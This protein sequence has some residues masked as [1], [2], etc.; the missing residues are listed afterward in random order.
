MSPTSTG[1]TTWLTP[2]TGVRDALYRSQILVI[3]AG[4]GGLT[5]AL[6]LQRQGFRVSV[7]ERAAEL[8]ELG[9]GVIITPNAMHALNFLGIG[10]SIV[11]SANLA[12]DLEFRHFKTAKLLQRRVVADISNRYGAAVYQ[13]HRADL[14]GTLSS[15]VLANDPD[16]IHLDHAF[17]DLS[18]DENAVVARFA[19]G[20]V[21]EG[22]ALIGCDGGRSIV[23]ERLYGR[24][25]VAYAGQVAFRAIV[26]A[27]QLPKG[28]RLH[29]RCVYCGPDRMLMHYALRK[30]SLMNIIAIA[31]QHEWQEEQWA[32]HGEIRELSRLYID[33]HPNALEM[34][35]AVKPDVL[36]KWGLHDREPLPQW[37]VGRVS[38]LGDAAHPFTPFLGQGACMA[39]E[40]GTILSRCFAGTRNPSEALRLYETA[41]RKRANTAQLRSRERAKALQGIFVDNFD[42][43]TNTQDVELFDGLFAYNPVTAPIEPGPE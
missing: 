23:R 24:E 36:F 25:P 40:D 11:K 1:P 7:Y 13:V 41:R 37:T 10:A 39:I 30:S 3:G 43:E 14:H 4:I 15:A 27:G 8:S 12:G 28:I 9:A 2:A 32:I 21:A 20:S 38:L 19:N 34:I 17:V 6:S 31:R 42:S 16:C 29:D 18:Q 5:A 33:F 35:N 26:P 22:D